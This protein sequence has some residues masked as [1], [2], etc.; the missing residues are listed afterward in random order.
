MGWVRS[1]LKKTVLEVNGVA[2]WWGVGLIL[3][4]L[5]W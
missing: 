1:R 2:G 4:L 5:D 3:L